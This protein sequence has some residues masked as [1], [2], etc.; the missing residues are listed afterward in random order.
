MKMK[1]FFFFGLLMLRFCSLQAQETRLPEQLSLEEAIGIALKNNAELK[2]KSLNTAIFKKQEEQALREKIP[3]VYANYN[4]RRNL[5][6]PTTPVPAI[7]FNPNANSGEILPLQ[8]STNWTSNAGLNAQWDIFNP[9]NHGLTK[10]A[11]QKSAISATEEKISANELEFKVGSDYAAC[12]I[13]KK[14]LQLATADTVSKNKVL[15]MTREQYAAGRLK[16]TDL[17]QV[18][19]EKNEALSNLLKAQNIFIISKAQLLADMGFSPNQNYAFSFSDSLSNILTNY[20]PEQPASP[21]SLSLQK[22]GKQ[23]ELTHIQLQNAQYGFLPTVSLTG[24]YGANYF[25]SDFAL[26]NGENWYGN[27]YVG[28]SINVPITRGLNRVK[29]IEGLRL[30]GKADQESYKARQIQIQL[31]S[32]QAQ[33]DVLLKEKILQQKEKNRTLAKE[34]LEAVTSQFENGRLLSGDWVKSDFLFRQAKTDYLQAAYDYIIAKMKV[35]KVS[36]E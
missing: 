20:S 27:S 22:L 1:S 9:E 35:E 31:E 23:E 15:A 33:Q 8:F 29:K 19:S 5:I 10:E 6:I 28:L 4:L 26:L 2:V 14:Q 24:F 16:V 7:A 30:Q 18:S 25:D 17:N 34:N 13:A 32:F 21:N 12:I 36:K 3:D 11:R